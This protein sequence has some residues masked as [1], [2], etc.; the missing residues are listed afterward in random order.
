[1]AGVTAMA[2]GGEQTQSAHACDVSLG[3]RIDV[4]EDSGVWTPYLQGSN[5]YPYPIFSSLP[6]PFFS[7]FFFS[8]TPAQNSD[9]LPL[10]IW[11]LSPAHFSSKAP[12]PTPP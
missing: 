9:F 4:G 11:P 6:R 8:G 3:P 5:P 1:M 7:L 12:L 10:P 2:A